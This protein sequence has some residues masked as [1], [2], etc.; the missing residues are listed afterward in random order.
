MKISECYHVH[1]MARKYAQR[2]SKPTSQAELKLFESVMKYLPLPE[3]VPFYKAA[4]MHEVAC[5]ILKAE[6]RYNELFIIYRAQGWY[7]EG[8]QLA[9]STK[10]Y[11]DEATFIFFKATAELAAQSGRL[12]ESTIAMLKKK[13]DSQSGIGAKANMIYGCAVQNNTMIKTAR[14]FFTSRK[15]HNA[16]GRIEAFIAAIARVEYDP[17]SHT[18]KNILL[19]RNENL[20]SLMLSICKEIR[21]IIAAL[22][23]SK[24]PSSV[25]RQVCSQFESFYGL[26]KKKVDEE[27]CEVYSVPS[28]SYTWTNRLLK[29]LKF[30]EEMTDTDGMLQLEIATV[31]AGISTH[32][33]SFIQ[34]WMV[35][36][37]L[38]LIEHLNESLTRHPLHWEM[39]AGGYLLH[40]QEVSS[41][42]RWLC[43]AFEVAYYGSSKVGRKESLFKAVLSTISPQAT[44]YFP[45][46]TVSLEIRSDSLKQM[47]D[48]QVLD[49]LTTS[50]HAFNFNS[51]FEAWRMNCVSRKG[52]QKMKQIL[53]SRSQQYNNKKSSKNVDTEGF[54]SVVYHKQRSRDTPHDTTPPPVFVRDRN[55]QYQHMILLWL[56]SC[57]SFRQKDMKGTL[58]SCTIAVYNIVVPIASK[59][60]IWKT[61]SVSSL[62]NVV[63]IHTIA[64]LTM[65]AACSARFQ[66]EG[67]IYFPYAYKNV[68]EVFHHMNRPADKDFFRS[69]ILYIMNRSGLPEV[70][71]KLQKMLSLL[72]KV[73]IGTHNKEFNPLR[74]ALGNEKCLKNGEARHCL[75]FVLTLFCNI[76]LINFNSPRVLQAYRIQIFESVKHCKEPLLMEVYQLFSSSRTLL[77]CCGTIRKLLEPSMDNILQANLTFNY[78]FNDI[79]IKF[80]PATL[81]TLKFQ[82]ELLQL[83]F[84]L[85]PQH[86]KPVT[87]RSSLNAEAE[88]FQLTEK[89]QVTSASPTV[90][91]ESYIVPELFTMDSTEAEEDDPETSEALAIEPEQDT[92]PQVEAEKNPTEDF[93]F[94][95]ICACPVVDSTQ[96][97]PTLPEIE[98]LYYNHCR[99]ETHITNGKIKDR[100]DSEE[101]DY[102]NPR[103]DELLELLPKCESLYVFRRDEQLC[104]TVSTTESDIKEM[105]KFVT[106][107]RNSAEWRRGVYKLENDFSGKLEYMRTTLT[108]LVE[109]TQDIK[110]K[111]ER[112]E[113][114]QE[115]KDEE[116]VKEDEEL[117]ED[118]DI[119]QAH[120][121]QGEKG[122]NKSRKRKRERRGRRSK[123]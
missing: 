94:C 13:L 33:E 31:L 111:I 110:R 54:Q 119:E 72:L 7:N 91:T 87:I 106:D 100:F 101:R 20:L 93:S 26:E 123:K 64:L 122:K 76:A 115:K 52:S 105:D 22:D 89:D 37:R 8:I 5:E 114:Q 51:W 23:P 46:A 117:E 109:E 55:H 3:R 102:F 17:D 74:Y 65:H 48:E 88:P 112:D 36:D 96:P 11:E 35:V 97:E 12:Q 41:Y 77:G 85:M 68:V 2:L 10:R 120:A 62:L 53:I 61:V 39:V 81:T 50:D 40:N 19:N 107:I 80:D 63:T 34:T 70:P 44:C 99:T 49:I 18:W 9:K 6:G 83:P 78:K 98:N 4:D 27:H 16:F 118:E 58:A 29:E 82:Q 79:D 66:Q 121:D 67:C 116:E 84:Q 42:F 90:P 92:V 47:M 108:R 95:S 113:K 86:S 45:V 21:H 15:Y 75:V 32:M 69:C 57:E 25:Q 103:R 73:M 14:D 30:D 1:Y 28:S 59:R 71:P 43:N 38:H 60:S 56:R 104:Q 24:D